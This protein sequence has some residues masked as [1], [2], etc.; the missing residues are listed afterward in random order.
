MKHEISYSLNVDASI[1]RHELYEK[2]AGDHDHDDPSVEHV[3][4][5]HFTNPHRSGFSSIFSVDVY[6][7]SDYC[8]GRR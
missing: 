2:L 4:K 5:E 3:M 6:M 8:N 1:K 7:T